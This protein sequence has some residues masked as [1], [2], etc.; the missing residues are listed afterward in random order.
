MR[1][2]PLQ[3]L[4]HRF[5]LYAFLFQPL[6]LPLHNFLPRPQPTHPLPYHLKLLGA[7]LLAQREPLTPEL[8]HALKLRR[9]DR[10]W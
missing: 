6:F 2:M 10:G 1:E 8:H 9:H 3:Y 5:L 4:Q 7:G